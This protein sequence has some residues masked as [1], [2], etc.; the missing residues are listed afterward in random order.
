VQALRN[1][2]MNGFNSLAPVKAWAMQQA[3]G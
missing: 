3:M 1:W 2:G